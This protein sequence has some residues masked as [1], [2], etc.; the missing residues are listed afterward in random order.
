MGFYDETFKYVQDRE[1]WSRIIHDYDTAN[2]D[3][4]L[5]EK[6]I[7]RSAI[8]FRDDLC[9]HRSIFSL[10]ARYRNFKRGNYSLISIRHLFIPLYRVLKSLPIH[11]KYKLYAG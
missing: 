8:S 6:S 3:E 10:K 5:G 7:E 9:L 2:L 11:L 1:L 4:I